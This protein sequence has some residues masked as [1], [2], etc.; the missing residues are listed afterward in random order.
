MASY[1]KAQQLVLSAGGQWSLLE[2]KIYDYFLAEISSAPPDQFSFEFEDTRFFSLFYG[3]T[4]RSHVSAQ[5]MRAVCDK[6]SSTK[7]SYL[8]PETGEWQFMNLLPYCSFSPMD[9]KFRMEVTP[10]QARLIRN[11]TVFAPISLIHQSKYDTKAAYKLY[12][13]YSLMIM[14]NRE[15]TYSC[16]DFIKLLDLSEATSFK[17]HMHRTI[18]PMLE[19]ISNNGHGFKAK[20]RLDSLGVAS[21][22]RGRKPT[23]HITLIL[24]LD[25]DNLAVLPMHEDDEITKALTELHINPE[26]IKV[27]RANH[28]KHTIMACYEQT[29]RDVKDRIE[30]GNPIKSP[31]SWFYSMIKNDAWTKAIHSAT[32]PQKPSVNAS[33][34]AQQQYFDQ[35]AYQR[36][37]QS[38]FLQYLQQPLDAQREILKDFS[39]HLAVSSTADNSIIPTFY[40][41]GFDDPEVK[42]I[43]TTWLIGWKGYAP[44]ELQLD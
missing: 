32:L 24:E 16:E 18:R 5:E 26:N 23:T 33:K 39:K 29:L 31:S 7:F 8:D 38:A 9:R 35:V 2:I 30:K 15:T 34:A 20:Y 14:R 37:H 13:I 42:S 3:A 40:S 43:F 4:G 17:V 28:T 19:Q 6:I 21:H 22:G 36:R 25:M 10:T 27:L 41:E 44:D 11:P 1:K 12:Q